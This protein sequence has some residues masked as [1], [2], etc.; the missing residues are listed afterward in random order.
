MNTIHVAVDYTE[1]VE[2]TR[3]GDPD[4]RWDAD[5]LHSSVTVNGL[6]VVPDD[7]TWEFVLVP[8]I[9]NPYY[10]VSVKYSTGDSFHHESGLR[11]FVSLVS[12]MKDAKLIKKAIEQNDNDVYG[13]D[14]TLSNG[15]KH[16]VDA[17]QWYGYFESMD[18]VFIDRF[19]ITGE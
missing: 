7:S 9:A 16:H 6:R 11:A 17:G 18:G 15:T 13:F 3:Q 19:D 1:E 8:P 12:S 4:D 2:V 10:L 5:D 14:V